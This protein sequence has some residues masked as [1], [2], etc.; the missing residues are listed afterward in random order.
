MAKTRLLLLQYDA[1]VLDSISDQ[2]QMLEDDTTVQSYAGRG[3][4]LAY[5]T[6]LEAIAAHQHARAEKAIKK[7]LQEESFWLTWHAHDLRRKNLL[8]QG[9]D[10]LEDRLACEDYIQ[11]IRQM[12]PKEMRK[13]IVIQSPPLVA[14]V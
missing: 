12:V 5:V 14:L 4:A 2:L 13:L 10:R 11:K 3:S 9:I 1:G 6:A 7:L 8:A